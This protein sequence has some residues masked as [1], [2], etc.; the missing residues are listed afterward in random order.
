MREAESEI[1]ALLAFSQVAAM[2]VRGVVASC[3]ASSHAVNSGSA[4]TE[5]TLNQLRPISIIETR[6]QTQ[7]V[8]ARNM[9]IFICRCID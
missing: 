1:Y 4:I 2:R 5:N 7:P 6:T 8:A 9:Y 3:S